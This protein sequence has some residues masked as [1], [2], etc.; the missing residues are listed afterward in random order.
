MTTTPGLPDRTSGDRDAH[1]GRETT[2]RR[3]TTTENP[4]EAEQPGPFDGIAVVE[5]GQF[6]VVPF[7]AQLLADA[8]AR[9]IKVEPPKGD[10]YRSGTAP[11]ASGETRQFLIKNRGKQSIGIDLAHPQAPDVVHRLIEMADVVLVNLSPAAVRRRGLDYDS[12]AARNP[13]AV[14]GA[15][16]AFGHTGPEAGLPG[17]DVVVQARSGLMR[18]LGAE[19]D[20]LPHHSEVQAADYATAMLLFGGI[21]SALFA[22]ERT[23]KGQQVEASLLGGALALQ[24]NSLAHVHGADDWRHEFVAEHLPRLRRDGAKR[25]EIEGVRR[26]MRPDPPLHTAHYRTFRTA[27]GVIAIGAGSPQTRRRL[28]TAAGL[29][30]ELL[31]TDAEA[32]RT[33]LAVLIAT[34]TSADWVADLLARDV[35]V[36]EV[37]HL[38]EMLFDPHVEAEGLVADYEHETIGRYRGLGATFRMS[39]TPV[40]T[41]AASPPFAS[42]TTELLAE[43]GFDAAAVGALIDGGAVVARTAPSE[44]ARRT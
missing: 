6:V 31:E 1:Q 30:E 36:A 43:L 37:R 13:R 27:D 16:S 4:G 5:F 23:G 10:A 12:V 42:H 44:P 24:N 9:V 14:Y 15:V 20:G 34:R 18:S 3:A 7:C 22:R 11:L 25:A 19:E 8:G 39:E 2:K 26:A 38:D 40:V 35:P 28:A 32:F 17:M 33:Q 41:R 21:A 29:D